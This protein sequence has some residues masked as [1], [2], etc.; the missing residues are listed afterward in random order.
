MIINLG[1]H[2]YVS[3]ERDLAS[4]HYA[5][6]PQVIIIMVKTAAVRLIVVIAQRLSITYGLFPH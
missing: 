1:S 2:S 3:L 6:D 5:D 4:D